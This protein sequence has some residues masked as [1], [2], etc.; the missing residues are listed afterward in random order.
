M[1]TSQPSLVL[2]ND[3]ILGVCEALGEDFRFNPIF[4]R[5]TF[6]VGLLWNPSAMV[7]A[8]LALGLLVAVSRFL[9][10]NPRRSAAPAL[11]APTA[12]QQREEAV[13]EPEPLA[14]AA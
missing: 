5:V 10:P 3:T 2:R 7:A 12:D 1:E 11:A 8:Y 9:A 14:V 13:V 4:L 6:A